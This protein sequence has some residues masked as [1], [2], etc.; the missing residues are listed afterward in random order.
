MSNETSSGRRCGIFA[1]ALSTILVEG[2][3]ERKNTQINN[4][5]Y[6]IKSLIFN[7]AFAFFTKPYFLTIYLFDSSFSGMHHTHFAIN[8]MI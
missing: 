8:T 4:N 7:Y 1:I 3:F 5:V 6:L 2:C